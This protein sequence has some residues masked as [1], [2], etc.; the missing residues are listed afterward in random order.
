MLTVLHDPNN[1][2]DYHTE[3]LKLINYYQNVTRDAIFIKYYNINVPQSIYEQHIESS[4]D[5]YGVSEIKFDI[6][7]LTPARHI[8]AISNRT[9]NVTDLK[10]TMLDG[11][12]TI[13]V[14]SLRR[15]RIHDVVVFY[16]PVKS[17]YEK[18][19]IF[20][21]VNF[22]TPVNILHADPEVT[23]FE[24]E[25]EYAPLICV[26]EL[27]INEH[28]VYDMTKEKYL[29]Y[30]DYVAFIDQL[31]KVSALAAQLTD[32]FDINK[33][34]YLTTEERDSENVRLLP[35]EVN[36]M[37]YYFKKH[38]HNEWKRVLENLKSPYGY[39]DIVGTPAYDSIQNIPFADMSNNLFYVLNF[40]SKQVEEHIWT[41]KENPV[42]NIDKLFKLGK[43]LYDLVQGGHLL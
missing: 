20:R 25:L 26:N 31:N 36:E 40:D 21:V 3:Y 13:S 34:V 5:I 15:P 7:D 37:I 43:E 16:P 32:F 42:T 33:D 6:Y 18:G 11:T 4:F 35:V 29:S 17:G 9:S 23:H 28:Y 19:E 1:V 22:T 41:E 38:F 2:Q 30:Q 39:I 12:T 8:Q 24:L 27:K 10:G 14:Y